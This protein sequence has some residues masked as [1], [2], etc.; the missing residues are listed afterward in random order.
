V[1]PGSNYRGAATPKRSNSRERKES[2][3]RTAINISG[4][5]TVTT[6][7]SGTGTVTPIIGGIGTVITIT[8]VSEIDL[9]TA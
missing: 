4:T 6:I 7:I 1:D 9:L 5:G 8:N 3:T 2:I